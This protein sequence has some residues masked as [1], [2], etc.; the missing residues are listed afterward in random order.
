MKFLRVAWWKKVWQIW[1]VSNA[2]CILFLSM[3]N[4]VCYAV[5]IM[6]NIAHFLKQLYDKTMRLFRRSSGCVSVFILL[7]LCNDVEVLECRIG[8]GLYER[9][10][11]C[12]YLLLLNTRPGREWRTNILFFSLWVYYR[13]FSSKNHEHAHCS[14]IH[15]V[16]MH[17]ATFDDP[18]KSISIRFKRLVIFSSPHSLSLL[19]ASLS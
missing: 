15:I 9:L 8:K 13:I 1:L 10:D 5:Q 4:C 6:N 17:H 14:T 18:T 12:S 11:K 3:I 7:Y 19:M 16:I 2:W